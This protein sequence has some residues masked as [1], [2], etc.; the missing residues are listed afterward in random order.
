MHDSDFRQF[1]NTDVSQGSAATLLRCGGIV[2]DDFVAY[3]LVSSESVSEK[4]LKIGQHLAKLWTI[5]QW[6]VFFD[7]QC[8][9][10]V[11][12]SKVLLEKVLE[13]QAAYTLIVCRCRETF[14][15]PNWRNMYSV[16]PSAN[17]SLFCFFSFAAHAF[18]AS[19]PFAT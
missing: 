9:S 8:T 14:L 17:K 10:L 19:T 13:E 3:L 12:A 1:S 7:S 6:L 16:S 15:N 11:E 5:S 18:K 2:N 4:I